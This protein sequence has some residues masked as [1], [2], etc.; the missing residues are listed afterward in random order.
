MHGWARTET[1]SIDVSPAQVRRVVPVDGVSDSTGASPAAA[2]AATGGGG[3]RKALLPLLMSLTALQ[4]LALLLAV[5]TVRPALGS[6]AWA[7]AQASTVLLLPLRSEPLVTT[8]SEP[9]R[10]H[11][12]ASAAA[13][14]GSAASRP[15]DVG[16]SGGPQ[17]AAAWVPMRAAS[18]PEPCTEGQASL[19]VGSAL[20]PRYEAATI[21]LKG[22]R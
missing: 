3:G 19:L 11:A 2:F 10:P 13:L 14:G 6:D 12:P 1:C 15:P 4:E 7:G 20:L 16:V 8:A 18:A 21:C 22:R 17:S 5:V 9:V